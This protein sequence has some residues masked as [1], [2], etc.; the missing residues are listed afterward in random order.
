MKRPVSIG[1]A[2]L[3]GFLLVLFGCRSVAPPG[4]AASPWTPP[5]WAL[6]ESARDPE[7]LPEPPD[8]PSQ[9]LSLARCVDIALANSPST[10]RAWHEA[11][12]AAA[13]LGRAESLRYPRLSVSGSVNYSRD[14]FNLQT[15]VLGIDTDQDVFTY[16]PAL[17][18]TYLL[19]DFGGVS[20]GIEEARQA[21]LAA[22]FSF[23]RSLQDLLLEV[24]RAYYGL[25]SARSALWA[26]EADVEDARTADEAARERYDAGLSSKLDQLQAR[27]SYQDALYRLEQA[28]GGLEASRAELT[29]LLG[30]SA[31]TAFEIAEPED[32]IPPELPA[33]EL[34]RLVEEG[35]RLR[36]DIA[37]L[38]ASLRSR[39]AAVSAAR[40]SLYPSLNLGGRAD[41]LWYEYNRGP[42]LYDDSYSYTGYLALKW[43]IFTGFADRELARQAEAERDAAREDLIAAELGASAEVWTRY[44]AYNTAVRK[45]TFS[46]AFLESARESSEL[47][48][49]GYESGLK[50]IL[51]LL[52]SQSALSAARSQV[53]ASER[54]VFVALAELTHAAG[55]LTREGLAFPPGAGE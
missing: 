8:D 52:Q 44:Y 10:R 33:G 48:R 50:S 17:E 28:R 4:S 20:G 35:L 45:Y 47:A 39:Q 30:F 55:T 1:L 32:T 22:N 34:A 13:G 36:P 5:D 43:D 2:S 15:E 31:G 38:R 29:R 16:G 24:G 6:R 53:I 14:H 11:R 21:L 23:N 27:S 12:A 49:E 19:F 37:A 40:S 46:R 7:P 3:A 51:D 54:D 25:N 9:P 42:E 18:L 41:H 26:A